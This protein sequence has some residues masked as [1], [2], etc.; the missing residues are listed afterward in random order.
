MNAK[1]RTCGRILTPSRGRPR[2]A[3]VKKIRSRALIEFAQ[4]DQFYDDLVSKGEGG[5]LTDQESPL[6]DV[7]RD[8]ARARDLR[9]VSLFWAIFKPPVLNTSQKDAFVKG[10][11]EQTSDTRL[12]NQDSIPPM[13]RLAKK[14][15]MLL[16]N[17]SR[18]F[19]DG[20]TLSPK[21][22]T[23]EPW[24]HDP[25]E[26]VSVQ[27]FLRTAPAPAPTRPQ[28]QGRNRSLSLPLS[29]ES[30]SVYGFK[31]RVLGMVRKNSGGVGVQSASEDGQ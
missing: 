30:K 26:V 10:M 4:R 15:E 14:K 8:L 13:R 17:I 29:D 23:A 19:R 12:R 16:D 25:T 28:R 7:D 20:D 6:R 11:M 2:N 27:D 18:R 1:E 3:Y 5:R 24:L 31:Q 21:A 22:R 9:D